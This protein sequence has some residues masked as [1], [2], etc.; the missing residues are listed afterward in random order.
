MLCLFFYNDVVYLSKNDLRTRLLRILT[1]LVRK[2]NSSS[3]KALDALYKALYGRIA[4]F[5]RSGD[6]SRE[7][8]IHLH[9]IKNK[10][11]FFSFDIRVMSVL[12]ND[13]VY[14]FKNG[15]DNSQTMC[16]THTH[17]RFP[18]V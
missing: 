6:V 2:T 18:Q 10:V 13:V 14:L 17:G 5:E 12:Y 3:M 7:P 16:H 1:T 9:T 11:H 8:F 15:L 4:Q